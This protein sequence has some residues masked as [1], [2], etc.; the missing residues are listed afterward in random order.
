MYK[1]YRNDPPKAK[2][3]L[4]TIA[5]LGIALCVGIAAIYLVARGCIEGAQWLFDLFTTT[6]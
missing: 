1:H 6:P 3:I 2:P 5:I 4:Q